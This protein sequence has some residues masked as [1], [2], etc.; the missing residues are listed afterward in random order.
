MILVLI[1][2]QGHKKQGV[3]FNYQKKIPNEVLDREH[4]RILDQLF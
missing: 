2:L 1:Q 4:Q 3:T